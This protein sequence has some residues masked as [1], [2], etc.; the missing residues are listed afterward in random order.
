MQ[1]LL[2]LL[3]QESSGA[4]GQALYNT[5]FAMA[6]PSQQVPIEQPLRVIIADD[7]EM[8]ASGIHT[9]LQ[10]LP[11]VQII[12]TAST[13]AQVLELVEHLHPHILFQD[14]HL[15]DMNGID[16]IKTLRYHERSAT[17]K[18]QEEQRGKGQSKK[19]KFALPET[20]RLC[21][22]AMT[23]Y[24]KNWVREALL[25]GA[26]GF[27]SKEEKRES[28]ISSI[29]WAAACVHSRATGVW[30]SPRWQL[31]N[32]FIMMLNFLKSSSAKLK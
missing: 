5:A 1:K 18:E 31:S 32:F 10:E 15:P 22:I 3:S 6:A 23:G 11:F 29:Y 12:A 27:L 8:V 17:G 4:S 24:S 21:I 20:N 2:Y 26:D 28:V 9:W 16:V 25:S 14:L 7:H 13:G 30:V 19:E